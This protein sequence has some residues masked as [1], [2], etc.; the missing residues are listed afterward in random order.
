[1]RQNMTPGEEA[2]FLGGFLKAAGDASLLIVK[3]IKSALEARLRL[4]V[5]ETTVYRMLKRHG[6]RKVVPRPRHPRQDP[7]ADETFKKGAA[8]R[9]LKR[10]VRRRRRGRCR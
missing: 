1:M 3:E 7:K 6:W 5:R 10:R 8:R 4:E 2:E 9:R